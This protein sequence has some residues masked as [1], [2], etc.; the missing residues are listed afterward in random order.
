MNLGAILSRFKRIPGALDELQ[1]EHRPVDVIRKGTRE[2]VFD[3]PGIY[4]GP[5]VPTAV[6]LPTDHVEPEQVRTGRP[7][8][9]GTFVKQGLPAMLRAGIV[10][11]GSPTPGQIVGGLQAGGA[12][13]NNRNM[14]QVAVQRQHTRDA[15][16][17]QM[18]RAKLDEISAA[19]G[20]RKA[21]AETAASKQEK[22][23]RGQEY[24]EIHQRAIARGLDPLTAHNYAMSGI[25]RN[26]TGF[27]TLPPRTIEAALADADVRRNRDEIDES[28][29]NGIRQRLMDTYRKSSQSKV[30]GPAAGKGP[31]PIPRL[32]WRRDYP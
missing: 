31:S 25:S 28:T 21:Q 7:S 26:S 30:S 17:Q 1:F 12:D 27:I 9:F 22:L 24:D 15:M 11:A 10:A 5:G 6:D 19:A 32:S 8:R 3:I 16:D 29:Y 18:H 23:T 4:G 20:F 2:D 13:Q 14:L